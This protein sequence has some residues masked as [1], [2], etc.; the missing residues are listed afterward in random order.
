M[1]AREYKSFLLLLVELKF[2]QFQKVLSQATRGQIL[3]LREVTVNFLQ[4]KLT[5]DSGVI[6]K[7]RP[8][9]QF[10]IRFGYSK[11]DRELL[12]KWSKCLWILLHQ[13]KTQVQNL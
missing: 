8:Y 1:A 4:N 11:V 2:N 3:A 7:L 5:L 9:K 6:N 10:L 13:I 12:A